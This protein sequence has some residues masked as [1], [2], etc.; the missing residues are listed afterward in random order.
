VIVLVMV[1]ECSGDRIVL[2][3]LPGNPIL[4]YQLEN[5]LNSLLKY[6]DKAGHKDSW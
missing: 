4:V 3:G 5:R 6:L 1:M 2:G